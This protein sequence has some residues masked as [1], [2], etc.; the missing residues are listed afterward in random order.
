M[1]YRIFGGL[2]LV[3]G[4][5]L[6]TQLASGQAVPIVRTAPTTQS[7]VRTA[8]TA[9]RGLKESDFPRITKLGG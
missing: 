7:V 3:A 5:L 6:G 1:S 9:V 8:D 2:L 4:S